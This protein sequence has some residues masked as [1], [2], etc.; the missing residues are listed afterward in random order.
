METQRLKRER[1][2]EREILNKETPIITDILLTFT[3]QHFVGEN[4]AFYLKTLV[5]N[6]KNMI[7]E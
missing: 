2:K 6:L 1:K 5:T 7:I 4:C 3:L